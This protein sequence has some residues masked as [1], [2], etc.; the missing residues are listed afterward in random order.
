[1]LT[2]FEQLD[3]ILRGDETRI[4]RLRQGQLEIPISGVSLAVVVLAVISGASMASF[5]LFR[6]G[7]GALMQLVAS[8]VKLPLLFALTLAVTLPSLYVFNALIGSALTVASV[9]RL[10][11]ASTG[12]MLA[13]SASLAPIIVFFAAS[14]TS[15]PFMKLLIVAFTAVSGAL[16]LSFLLR[17]LERIVAAPGWHAPPHDSADATSPPPGPIDSLGGAGRVRALRVFRIWVAVFGL[18]G[19]QMAWVLRPFI[20]SPDLAFTWFRAR[21]SNF[22]LDVL[23]AVGDLLS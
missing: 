2:W 6:G 20:G 23:R 5:A 7:E 17:T 14:T 8:A 15:Y 4:D 12:V 16:G 19:A 18:V 21:Q 13:V 11:V 3:R 22:F 1:M 9:M 10:A